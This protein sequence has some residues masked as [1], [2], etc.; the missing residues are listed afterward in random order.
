L[1]EGK[2]IRIEGGSYISNQHMLKIKNSRQKKE[3]KGMEKIAVS[4]TNGGLED[5]INPVFG[6][7]Q[8]Y[9][10]VEVENK[11]IK[12]DRTVDNKAA[13][14]PGG[15][16]IQ[17]AQDIANQGVSVVITGNIGPNAL[18]ILSSAGI[19]VFSAQGMSVKEA[20]QAYLDGKLTEL[21]APTAPG[22][23]G[24]GAGMGM[25]MGGGRGAGRGGGGGMGRGRGG[26]QG[27]RAGF[28]GAPSECVCPSCGYTQPHQPGTPCL[29]LS[30]PSCGTKLVRKT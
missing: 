9:T 3:V 18:P 8:K 1:V 5:T 21:N 24:G 26:G 23:P 15:A 11:E 6:R 27:M 4:T 10:I 16:G 17:A 30:C 20:V 13:Q 2:A 19:R 14:M 22:M 25:R 7:C 12:S 29:N 28:G